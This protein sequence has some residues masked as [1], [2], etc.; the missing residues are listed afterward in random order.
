MQQAIFGGDPTAL[1][2]DLSGE[3]ARVWAEIRQAFSA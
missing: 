3:Y 1:G 2:Q